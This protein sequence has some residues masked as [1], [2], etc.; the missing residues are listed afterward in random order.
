PQL[1]EGGAAAGE[2]GLAERGHRQ[3]VEQRAV[4][5]EHEGPEAREAG[6][7]HRQ[8][9][10]RYSLPGSPPM[11]TDELLTSGATELATSRRLCARAQHLLTTSDW[12]VACARVL[13]RRHRWVSGGTD[14]DG[15]QLRDRIRALMDACRLPREASKRLWVVRSKG[16]RACIACQY[17][18]RSG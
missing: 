4:G 18:L 8:S 15:G 2:E 6:I 5:V 9:P 14:G 16:G 1:R 7:T 12:N 11:G 10:L 13:R 3:H 17:D